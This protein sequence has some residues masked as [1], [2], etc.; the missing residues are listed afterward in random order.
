MNKKEG[1]I[2]STIV[3]KYRMYVILVVL[4]IGF[5]ISNDA[6]LTTATLW[7]I[8]RQVAIIAIAS[9]GSGMVVIS[10]GVDI[11]IGANMCFS[12]VICA[13]LM[14]NLKMNPF[15]ACLIAVTFCTIVGFVHAFLVVK[16]HIAPMITGLALATSV[17]GIALL[18]S[19]G[20]S[21]N[22][23]P[24]VFKTALRR[25]VAGTIPVTVVIMAVL[26]I[27]AEII[28]DTTY[29]GRYLYAVGSNVEAAK[30][31]GINAD[32]IKMSAYVVSGLLAGI[33]GI[34]MCA[35]IGMGN[36]YAYTGFE[37]DCLTSVI[38]GGIAFTGGSGRIVSALIGAVIMGI[39]KTGLVLVGAGEYWQQV[40]SGI[41][42]AIV[43]GYD[44]Y[45]GWKR[46]HGAD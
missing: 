23:I 12:T 25:T 30:L 27:I 33:S 7:T 8:M 36:A 43:V 44:S 35:R 40:I 3:A 17:R 24:E 14:V 4:I 10:G 5:G 1:S 9:I 2:F 19:D 20:I 15:I 38:V 6:F 45:Q 18:V 39:L 46:E 32:A 34:L 42:L 37:M 26:Y 31:S 13:H 29:Y 28:L 11:G 21:I 16:I 41:I 22:G